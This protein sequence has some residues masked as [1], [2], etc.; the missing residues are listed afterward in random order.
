MK[1]EDTT[2]GFDA[3]DLGRILST[4]A[5]GGVIMS[6]GGGSAGDDGNVKVIFFELSKITGDEGTI[7]SVVESKMLAVTLLNMALLG[8]PIFR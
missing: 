8:R 6:A 7:M 1:E 5:G 2:I 4:T 3:G